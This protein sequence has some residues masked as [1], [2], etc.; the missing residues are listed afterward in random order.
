MSKLLPL[1]PLL[2]LPIGRGARALPLLLLVLQVSGIASFRKTAA[3]DAHSLAFSGNL[4]PRRPQPDFCCVGA[5]APVLRLVGPGAE[6]EVGVVRCG[7]GE[8]DGWI[9]IWG[10]FGAGGGSGWITESGTGCF[11]SCCW[12]SLEFVW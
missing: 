8:K 11:V 9:G 3:F 12:F 5:C 6:K 7:V 4:L 10:I 2:Q 1:P